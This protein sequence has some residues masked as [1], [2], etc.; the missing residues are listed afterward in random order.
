MYKHMNM[1]VHIYTYKFIY[2]YVPK[3]AQTTPQ[4]YS[5]HM[6]VK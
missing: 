3:N 2:G 1:Y 5:S 6:L 4:L